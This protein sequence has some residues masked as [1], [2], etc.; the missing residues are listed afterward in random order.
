MALKQS[1]TTV[2]GIDLP[3]AYVRVTSFSGSSKHVQYHVRTYAD[4]AARAAEKQHLDEKNYSFEYK[5][6]Q[7]DILIA[8][9]TDLLAR[10]EYAGAVAV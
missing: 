6:G 1:T 9:Y 3:N 8:C 10:P 2:H 7:G 4:A 5:P